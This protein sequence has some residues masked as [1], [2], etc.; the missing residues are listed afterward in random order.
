MRKNT[1]TIML[2]VLVALLSISISVAQD[3][4]DRVVV[5]SPG[6]SGNVAD[7]DSD[8]ILAEIEAATNT[9]IEFRKVDGSSFIDQLNAAALNGQFPDI[10][11]TIGEGNDA[12]IASWIR[13]GVITPFTGEV[14][15]AAPNIIAQYEEI[16]LLNEI[17][18]NGEIYAQPTFWGFDTYPNQ[19]LVHIR[20]DLLEAYGME[21]PTTFEEYFDFLETAVENGETGVI[22]NAAE[23]L[24]PALNPFAGAYG[25]PYRGWVELED[26]SYGYW[27][28]QPGMKDALL[29]FR[30]MVT[31][32][33][34][35]EE[36]WSLDGDARDRYVAGQG[37]S[38]LFNGGGH[39][40]RIQND[41]DLAGHGGQEYL[42]PAPTV[43]G[44]TRGYTEEPMF[45]GRSFIGGMENNNP[46]AA[47][48]IL[49][50]LV[51]DEG[52]QLTVLGV[53][54]IDYE[55]QDGQFVL[56]D[57][58][59]ER[60][61][62]TEAGD[63]G[64]HP[65]ATQIVTWVPQNWQN[66]QLQY[67]KSLEFAEW[68]D[69]MWENQGMYRT[70][71]YGLITTTPMWTEFRP[72]GDELIQRT[73]LD[74]VFATTDAEAEALFDEFVTSWLSIGGEAATEEMSAALQ[75]IYN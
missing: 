61:F 5:W 70:S 28:V 22:F 7:W 9:E 46:V 32:G 41:M 45:W 36:S 44:E 53:E 57:A 65:L 15:E 74:I 67:G 29:L 23:G 52:L 10:V 21:P 49:N 19:G 69:A 25:L 66:W 71:A 18:V 40:G 58:R 64:A 43:D 2:V 38:L 50:Y 75:E 11:G 37:A 26:G 56:L 20:A 63:T 62:P 3:T 34:V 51:S 59:T 8:P 60:G 35:D 12:L 30:Q 39:I 24:G 4:P 13:D 16:P 42:L 47:A 55:V 33:L 27:A 17:R 54:G 73:F 1:Q 68:F 48:R 14:A 31:S 6:D 72:T